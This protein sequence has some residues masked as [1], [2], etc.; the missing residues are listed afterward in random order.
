MISLKRLNGTEFCLNPDLIEQME[1]TPDT[2]I[3]LTTGN[4]IVVLERIPEVMDKIIDYR[5]RINEER[6]EKQ[7]SCLRGA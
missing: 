2:V 7:A 4:N 3:T 1:S 6:K 5:R